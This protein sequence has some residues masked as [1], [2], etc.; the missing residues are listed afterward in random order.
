MRTHVLGDDHASLWRPAVF[1]LSSVDKNAALLMSSAEM[2]IKTCV[3]DEK[4]ADFFVAR[5]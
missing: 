3:L 2:Y 4:R 1:H 5:L